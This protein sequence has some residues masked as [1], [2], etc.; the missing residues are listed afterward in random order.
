MLCKSGIF[1]SSRLELSIGCVVFRCEVH[2]VAWLHD[3]YVTFKVFLLRK[4][5]FC[6]EK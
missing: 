6:R 2:G 5:C 1:V 3:A 4:S